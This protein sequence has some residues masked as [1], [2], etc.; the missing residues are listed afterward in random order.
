M[1]CGH[2]SSHLLPSGFLGVDIFFVISGFVITASL[3]Q[4]SGESWGKYLSGFYS[5]RIKRLTPALLVCIFLTSLAGALLTSFPDNTIKTGFFAS[6]G[7]SNIYLYR[8]SLDYFGKSIS[9]N[10]FTHTWS[11]GVEEQ[12]YLIFPI[13]LS[14][15]GFS[16]QKK[17]YGRFAL[18]I[19]IS[20]LSAFSLW[21][22]IYLSQQNP[23]AA[24]YLMP[25][26]FWEL[27]AG[28]IFYLISLSPFQLFT[29]NNLITHLLF[30][31]S[32]AIL[33]YLFWVPENY[34]CLATIL[35]AMVT[36]LTILLSKKAEK[37]SFI[38]SNPY[39]VSIGTISYSLYLWHWP[40][41][42]LARNLIGSSNREVIIL[43]LLTL[44]IANL[45]FHI[46]ERPLRALNWSKNQNFTI[47]KGLF[48]SVVVAVL[49]I[50]V[51]VP[52]K[53]KIRLIRAYQPQA[54]FLYFSECH[55]PKDQ[56]PIAKC[57]SLKD[58]GRPHIF[59]MGDSHAGNL[60][61]GLEIVAQKTSR[62][63]RYLTDRALANH[64]VGHDLC[65]GS[66]CAH[67]EIGERIKFL[68]SNMKPGDTF[69]FSMARD[70]LYSENSLD[71]SDPDLAIKSHAASEQ[72]FVNLGRMIESVQSLGGKVILVE[73]IP[74]LCSEEDYQ[75]WTNG[76]IDTCHIER[77]RSLTHRKALS[78]VYHRLAQKFSNVTI[79][80]PHPI[81]CPTEECTNL[82]NK[83]LVYEDSSPHLT[84][85]ASELLAVPLLEYFK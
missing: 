9:L 24:F 56:N 75:V 14:I 46:V 21:S 61:K 47:V 76:L 33:F 12:F 6:F 20:I 66:V 60:V 42:S 1:I 27:G 40:I 36:G 85:E 5:R 65:D 59:L 29:K 74:K 51:C 15:L 64:I 41:L 11:L 48:A 18:S 53:D 25:M 81:F 57:L 16:R 45:S 13:I 26:R 19:A 43:L 54:S 58:T 49:L 10:L 32:L 30:V 52:Y 3:A 2:Y 68:K 70:R 71:L 77:S 4:R 37:L 35:I 39:L 28:C 17:F 83:K 50:K 80:D 62:E 63:L 31:S 72:I 23:Q 55:I 22:F 73:D 34:R 78:E 69:I 8:E 79:F 84:V 7:A 38:L 67:D 82:L 44:I